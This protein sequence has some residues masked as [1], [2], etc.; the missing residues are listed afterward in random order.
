MT[1]DEIQAVA[2][3][4]CLAGGF[5]PDEIMPNDGP[6]WGYYTDAA[7]AAIAAIDAARGKAELA[8]WTDILERYCREFGFRHIEFT[9][10]D[11]GGFLAS[12]HISPPA[13]RVAQVV[14]WLRKENGICD[15]R[16]AGR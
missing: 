10:T 8:A 7:K 5:D 1:Q 11:D 14:E 3:A 9:L 12:H 2:R 15:C 6:R 4:M 13:D 16:L